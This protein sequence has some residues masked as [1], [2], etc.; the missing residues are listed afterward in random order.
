MGRLLDVKKS[1][2]V[3]ISIPDAVWN[4]VSD[5]AV[6]EI[7]APSF[8][9]Y[10]PCPTCGEGAVTRSGRC[11]QCALEYELFHREDNGLSIR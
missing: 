9:E 1:T 8:R 4:L 7:A 11:E 5:W 10:E 6:G 2:N 3:R